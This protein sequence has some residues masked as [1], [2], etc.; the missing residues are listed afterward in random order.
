[1]RVIHYKSSF[2]YSTK[3]KNY[4]QYTKIQMH[5]G[6]LCVSVENYRKWNITKCL[7]E[8]E[9]AERTEFQGKGRECRIKMKI[10]ASSQKE[11]C[12]CETARILWNTA[13]VRLMDSQEKEIG[14]ITNSQKMGRGGSHHIEPGQSAASRWY[15]EKKSSIQN[16]PKGVHP[17]KSSLIYLIGKGEM[18]FFLLPI[19]F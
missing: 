16:Q 5:I 13:C 14:P 19:I 1:M 12:R 9:I 17:F 6:I 4:V 10:G 11:V 15:H 2:F 3:C 7:R 8:K 18:E